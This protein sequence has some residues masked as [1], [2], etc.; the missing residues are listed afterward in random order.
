MIPDIRNKSEI[1]KYLEVL[2]FKPASKSLDTLKT[3]IDKIFD[4][5]ISNNAVQVFF[6]IFPEENN[7][8]IFMYEEY[9]ETNQAFINAVE[10]YEPKI[11]FYPLETL[12]GETLSKPEISMD[13]RSIDIM[14]LGGDGLFTEFKVCSVGFWAKAKNEAKTY[15]VTADHCRTIPGDETEF[16]YGAWDEG[17]TNEF[18]GSMLPIDFEIYDFGLIDISNM[19][20]SLTT[21]PVIRN[22]DSEQFPLLPINNGTPV[23]SHGVHLCKSGYITHVTCGFVKVLDFIYYLQDGIHYSELIMTSM[24]VRKGDSGGTAFAYSDLNT[25]ILNGIGTAGIGN[26]NSLILPLSIITEYGDIE[27]ITTSTLK[28]NFYH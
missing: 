8:V 18:I 21:L 4:L 11:I 10:E 12:G 23:S 24:L 14:V 6:G 26:V 16:V 28:I 27:P 9:N 15:I 13:K 25:V 22:T 5:I 1:Q 17:R 2:S 7:I 20:D 3:S 19:S